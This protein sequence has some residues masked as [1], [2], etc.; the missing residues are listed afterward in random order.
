[1][2]KNILV[3]DDSKLARDLIAFMVT[4]GGYEVDV[5]ED[6]AEALEQLATH[7]FHLAVVDLNMP[8]MDGYELIR[9]IRA[10]EKTADLAVI[11]AT[12]EAEA[13]DKSR[14]VEAGADLYMVKPVQ[15]A[16]LLANIRM[17]IGDAD[18]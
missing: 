8:L 10:E 17:L 11:I 5:A 14:G 1:M 2:S 16:D 18:D 4:A 9:R 6:G 12:T 15:E 3:V 13:K 7:T